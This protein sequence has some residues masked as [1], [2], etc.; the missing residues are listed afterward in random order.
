LVYEKLRKHFKE[1]EIHTAIETIRSD[2]SLLKGGFAAIAGG[3]ICIASW[4]LLSCFHE[5]VFFLGY[6]IFGSVVGLGMR[7]WGKGDNVLHA[8][9]SIVT[10]SLFVALFYVLGTGCSFVIPDLSV[11][12]VPNLISVEGMFLTVG[13]IISYMLG[14]YPIT[15]GGIFQKLRRTRR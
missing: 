15:E 6:L 2:A 10:Y 7:F 12:G 1:K 3:L 11:F 9:I 14:R 5:G 4:K 8:I 13:A